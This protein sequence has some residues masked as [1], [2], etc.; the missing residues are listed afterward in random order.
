[1]DIRMVFVLYFKIGAKF[2]YLKKACAPDWTQP[3][4]TVPAHLVKT[5]RA[6]QPDS[7]RPHAQT[8]CSLSEPWHHRHRCFPAGAHRLP[9]PMASRC[10]RAPPSRSPITAT[11]TTSKASPSRSPLFVPASFLCSPCARGQPLSSGPCRCAVNA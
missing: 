9:P 8:T 4:S 1:M 11:S 5:A 10:P 7:C 2:E 3:M 6:H